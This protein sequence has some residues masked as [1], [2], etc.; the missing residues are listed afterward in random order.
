MG[1]PDRPRI[2]LVRHLLA[3]ELGHV[4]VGQVL[5][6]DPTAKGVV[7]EYVAERLAWEITAAAGLR[8]RLEV[9]IPHPRTGQNLWL[10]SLVAIVGRRSDT[11]AP[12]RFAPAGPGRQD[13]RWLF[14]GSYRLLRAEA[15]ALGV[16]QATGL[17]LGGP[18]L[19]SALTAALAT[20]IAPLL[21]EPLPR[22][23]DSGT[24]EEYLVLV[25]T[26]VAARQREFLTELEPL[27]MTHRTDFLRLAP[28]TGD[29]PASSSTG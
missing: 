16:E 23:A 15:Y 29:S 19:P 7:A 18:A 3:H 27:V 26:V 1:L 8:A 2:A 21:A 22:Q 28:P 10:R 9:E 11:P 6:A 17:V 5:G 25:G 13:E 12:D 20:V 4:I 14:E 24:L